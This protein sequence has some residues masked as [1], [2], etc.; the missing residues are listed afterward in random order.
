[1]PDNDPT[2]A[3]VGFRVP[4]YVI[5]PFARPGHV[6]HQVFD[7]T[8]ILKMVEWRFGLAPLTPRDRAA[9]NLADAL[10]FSKPNKTGSIPSVVDPGPHYC[11][12]DNSV[13]MGNTD[14]MWA[15][16]AA[17]PLMR[18]WDVVHARNRR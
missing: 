8:S 3:Q 4:T 7:H 14:P 16:L 17:S 5:S 13:G 2:H 15:E 18:G 6:N 1:M 12:G 11:Q 9:A 10:D